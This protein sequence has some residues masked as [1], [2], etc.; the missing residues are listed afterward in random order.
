MGTEIENDWISIRL[1]VASAMIIGSIVF[2][3]A[4]W[5]AM[6]FKAS[7]KAHMFMNEVASK[8]YLFGLG[9]L[10]SLN[11]AQAGIYQ[12]VLI[13]LTMVSLMILVLSS[14]LPES[15]DDQK[16]SYAYILYYLFLFAWYMGIM[17]D[18]FVTYRD[19]NWTEIDSI[20]I[21]PFYIHILYHQ[22]LIQ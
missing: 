8:F 16:R 9:G 2:Y 19:F 12:T 5:Y 22:I 11:F 20:I 6:W 4:Y 15:V 7:R 10:L 13:Y 21:F 18:F 3:V 14:L 1:A 17:I